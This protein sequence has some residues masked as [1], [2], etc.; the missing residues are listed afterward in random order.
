MRDALIAIG[1]WRDLDTPEHP[2][3]WPEP[4]RLVNVTWPHRDP[5]TAHLNRGVEF[6]G[7]MG[8]SGCRFCNQTNGSLDLTDG[9]YL[10]PE[11]LAHY[12]SEHGVFLPEAFVAHVAEAPP[13]PGKQAICELRNGGWPVEN[14]SWNDFCALHAPPVTTTLPIALDDALAIAAAAGNDQWQ[15][16]IEPWRD[17]WRVTHQTEQRSWSDYMACCNAETLQRYIDL[18]RRSGSDAIS[19]EEARQIADQLGPPV[20][21]FTVT[22]CPGEDDRGVHW[23]VDERSV[24]GSSMGF[25]CWPMDRMAWRA[26]VLRDRAEEE[27]YQSEQ[28]TR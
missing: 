20:L 3:V 1:Y 27:E 9:V 10:W 21:C 4:Q 7:S 8:I 13:I 5:V 26:L 28:H 24:D 18:W 15:L 14:Q 16:V 6:L 2:A 23:D 11:G 19:V 17:L 22:E 12:V 25:N